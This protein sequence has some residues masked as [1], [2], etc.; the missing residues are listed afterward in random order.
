MEKVAPQMEEIIIIVT[1][2]FGALVIVAA[3]I[4]FHRAN[5]KKAAGVLMVTMIFVGLLLVMHDKLAE[6]TLAKIG[7]FKL[8]RDQA[9]A[10]AGVIQSLKSRVENQSATIDAVAAQAKNAAGLSDK[11]ATQVNAADQKLADLNATLSTAKVTLENLQKDADFVRLIQQAQNDDRVAFDELVSIARDKNNPYSKRAIDAFDVIVDA[12]SQPIFVT[13]LS[14]PWSPGIEPATLS[15]DNLKSA[16]RTAPAPVKPALIEYIATHKDIATIDK[17]DFLMD[18]IKTD[19]SLKAVEYAGRYFDQATN[20]KTN[21]LAV[22]DLSK[23]WI[24]HRT[25]Y[26]NPASDQK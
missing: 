20:Q 10:D 4:V 14:V 1:K 16:F 24:E 19:A 18:V 11:A 5:A 15:F 25:E 7:T 6:V 8:L 17:L 13:N 21:P 23:W 3:F 2:L 22:D 26:E 12:H 9:S